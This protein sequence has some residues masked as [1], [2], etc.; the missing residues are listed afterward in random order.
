[1]QV[2]ADEEVNGTFTRAVDGAVNYGDANKYRRGEAA[3]IPAFCCA[4]SPSSRRFSTALDTCPLD[5]SGID[6]IERRLS[7]LLLDAAFRIEW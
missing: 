1:M 5:L 7:L 6:I 4:W 3:S 2:L